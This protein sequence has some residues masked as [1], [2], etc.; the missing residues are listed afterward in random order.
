MVA[1]APHLIQEAVSEPVQEPVSEPVEGPVPEPVQ[2]VLGPG[3]EAVLE[4]VQDTPLLAPGSPEELRMARMFATTFARD[5]R[6]ARAEIYG[7]E[8]PHFTVHRALH[9]VGDVRPGEEL[10]HSGDL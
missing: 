4:P 1:H 9:Q 3:Q 5:T 8:N 2:E 7:E 10:V 6:V